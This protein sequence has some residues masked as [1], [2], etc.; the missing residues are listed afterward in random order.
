MLPGPVRVE[1]MPAPDLASTVVQRQVIEKATVLRA[2]AGM[3]VQLAEAASETGEAQEQ[4]PAEGAQQAGGEVNIDELAMRVYG[5]VKRRLS[6]EWE[7]LR[8]KF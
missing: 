1:S 5:E 8:R 4:V 6:I 3:M 2:P 7:R